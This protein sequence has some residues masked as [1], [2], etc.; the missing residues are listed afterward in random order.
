MNESSIYS[1]IARRSGG[2]IYIGVVGPVRTGKSTFIHRFLDTLV[3]PNIDNEYDK[4]RTLDQMPQSASGKTIMT[5]EPK[6]VPDES[7]K[8]SPCEGISL[9]VKM[10]DCVGYLVDG[11]LG[12]EENGESR[13]VNTPW[14]EEPMPFKE[15]AELGTSKVIGEHATIAMLV[16]TDGTISDIPRESYV[17]AEERVVRELREYKKPFA[18]ILNSKNPSS[19]EARAL[20][21]ELEEKYGAPVALV[22][23]PALNSD[24]ISEILR[25]VLG[26][27]PIKEMS[28]ELPEWTEALPSEHKLKA[29]ILESISSFADKVEKLG[30]I[31]RTLATVSTFER[32]EVDAGDGTARFNVPID[33]SEYYKTISE[34]TGLDISD[35]SSL[36]TNILELAHIRERYMK[37]A[38]ALSDVEEKGYGI[39]MPSMSELKLEEPRLVKQPNGYGVKVTAHA[40]SIH[41]IKTGI[42]A[43]LCPVIG[44]EEQSEEVVKFLADEFLE[45][46]EGVWEYNMFGKSLYDMVSDTMGAKLSHMPEESREKLGETLGKIINEGSNGLICILL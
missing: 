20:A 6:F 4:E 3:V 23:C 7:V 27:F 17:A 8:I 34:M 12:G 42:K 40:D 18:I 28:F 35:E 25:L 37:V 11:A 15:A 14:S 10:V 46:P 29:E 32:I 44:S 39:V 36:I 45:N 38:S 13:M 21:C 41:M 24:D 26:E 1:D 9:N 31:E 30:D 16:T 22:S 43:D 33:K 19:D 2:D 5:T